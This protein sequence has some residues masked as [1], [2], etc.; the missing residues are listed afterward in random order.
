MLQ[1]VLFVSN[2]LGCSEKRTA[3]DETDSTSAEVDFPQGLA[4]KQ[5]SFEMHKIRD[6]PQ[7]GQPCKGSMMEV[8]SCKL[9]A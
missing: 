1:L 9:D 5:L 6:L 4:I 8:E 3:S 2:H 7:Q